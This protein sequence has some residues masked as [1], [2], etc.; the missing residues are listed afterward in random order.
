MPLYAE[1]EVK[2]ERSEEIKAERRNERRVKAKPAFN[3]NKPTIGKP[4]HKKW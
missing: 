4:S 1:L 3:S 2:L